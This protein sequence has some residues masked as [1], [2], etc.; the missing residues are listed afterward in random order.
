[1]DKQHCEPC[2]CHDLY[3]LYEEQKKLS[4]SGFRFVCESMGFDTIP[5]ILSNGECPF[6]SFGK[7]LK[8]QFFTTT[9]FRLEGI[10]TDCCC[11]T[12]SLLIPVD[13]DG[14][15]IGY[16]DDV[17]SL[18]KTNICVTVDLHCFNSINPLSPKLV[19]RPLPIVEPK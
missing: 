10:D 4:F 8:G 19:N 3:Q 13:M 12:L 1:M 18:L 16:C 14:I 9:V 7:T 6:Q 5:F 17:Y 2:I 11:A 15:P